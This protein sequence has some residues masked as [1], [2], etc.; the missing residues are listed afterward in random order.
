MRNYKEEFN[1]EYETK[2]INSL[3][4]IICIH[5]SESKRQIISD[6]FYLNI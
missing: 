2:N 1:L 5:M 3:N 4:L 6:F